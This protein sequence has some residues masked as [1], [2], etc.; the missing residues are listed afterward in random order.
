MLEHCRFHH[1]YSLF[2]GFSDLSQEFLQKSCKSFYLFLTLKIEKK[3][4]F[5]V[6]SFLGAQRCETSG[7]NETNGGEIIDGGDISYII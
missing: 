1:E 2:I 6:A 5:P 3:S 4:P 7:G